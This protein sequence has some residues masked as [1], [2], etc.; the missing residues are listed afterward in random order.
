MPTDIYFQHINFTHM[1]KMPMGELIPTI[2]IGGGGVGPNGQNSHRQFSFCP[3]ANSAHGELKFVGSM[4]Y[5]HNAHE[6]LFAV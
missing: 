3:N 4:N 1:P 6:H 5:A 2:D